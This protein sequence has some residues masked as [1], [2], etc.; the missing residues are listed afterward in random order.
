MGQNFSAD[1][2]SSIRMNL[3]NSEI[4]KKEAS[5]TQYHHS[6]KIKTEVNTPSLMH[7]T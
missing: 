7:R 3:G 6:K 1:E 5:I 4:F 2:P